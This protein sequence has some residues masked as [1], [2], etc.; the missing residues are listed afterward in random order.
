MWHIYYKIVDMNGFREMLTSEGKEGSKL[1]SKRVITFI[2]FILV[3]IAFIMNIGWAIVVDPII[4]GG[5]I[6][7]VFAGL[8][9]TVGEHL[10]KKRRG[11]NPNGIDNGYVEDTYS[12][13]HS[14]GY[15]NDT[16]DNQL[17][18]N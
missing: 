1:S 15:N 16:H 18:D 5:M 14:H 7:I 13:T 9:V 4:L 10:L 12:H 3:C 2:A 8:G 11:E 6:N 17:G